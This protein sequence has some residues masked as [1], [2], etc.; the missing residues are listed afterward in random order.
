[1]D[2]PD[3]VVCIDPDADRLSEHPVIGHRLGPQRIDFEARRHRCAFALRVGDPVQNH[4]RDREHGEHD[5]Q[6]C[7]QLFHTEPHFRGQTDALNVLH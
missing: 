5:D 4:L 6:R 3:V 2:D 7:N 1:M